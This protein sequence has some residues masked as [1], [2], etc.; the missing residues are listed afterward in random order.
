MR[1]SPRDSPSRTKRPLS[2]WELPSLLKSVHD[3]R[4]SLPENPKERPHYPAILAFAHRNRFCVASQVQR[5]FSDKL[6]SDR[7]TRRHLT[8]LQALGYLDVAPT[9]N[10]SPL[11]P[12]VYFV[13]RRGVARLK[14]AYAE[15]G[16]EWKPTT[17]D[18]RRNEGTTAAHVVH[19]LLLTEFLLDVRLTIDQR[20]DLELL[21]IERRSLATHKDFRI[22]LDGRSTRLRPDGMFVFRQNGR[23]VMCCFVELDT[24]TMSKRQVL[25]KLRRYGAWSDLGP[26]H[27]Y[28]ANLY[29]RSGC[30][31]PE[32]KFRVLFVLSTSDRGIDRR[33]KDLL[34][35][36]TEA[37]T[38]IEQRVWVSA[39]PSLGHSTD[40]HNSLHDCM[41]RRPRQSS[42]LLFPR[43]T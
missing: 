15:L 22:G 14:R 33:A 28:L 39:Y 35:I 30:R 41:W 34:E 11:W 9:C 19:E 18:R 27:A 2:V 1:N 7:T 37:P 16:K 24:G 43:Q 31:N 3:H 4:K 38:M 17:I 6:G 26:G 42:A 23:G 10:T 40:G 13:T 12:K 29:R 32:Q 20:P 8:E 21:Q 5:R 25:Q 36:A